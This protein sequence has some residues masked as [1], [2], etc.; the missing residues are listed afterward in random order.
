MDREACRLCQTDRKDQVQRTETG[1]AVLIMQLSVATA[2]AA[3]PC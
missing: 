1:L 2:M 3:S